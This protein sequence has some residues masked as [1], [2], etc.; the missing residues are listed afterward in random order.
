MIT[1]GKMTVNDYQHLA[2]RTINRLCDNL[3][4]TGLGLAG[5][6]GEV[7]DL[8]KKVTCQGHDLDE[9]RPKLTEELGDISWYVALGCTVLGVPME[10]VLT[11]NIAKL[12]RRYPQG[13]S[14][15]RSINREE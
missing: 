1:H 7:A 5:E 10:D 6:S 3:T 14:A 11:A 12:E 15:E 2:A 9:L 4:N 13:F 8:I